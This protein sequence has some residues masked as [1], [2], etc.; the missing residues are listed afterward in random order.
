VVLAHL[1][2]VAPPAGAAERKGPDGAYVLRLYQRV[3]DVGNALLEHEQLVILRLEKKR[4][5]D[6]IKAVARF[7]S[8]RKQMRLLNRLAR[9]LK[10]QLPGGD[11]YTSRIDDI[12]SGIKPIREAHR[13]NMVRFKALAPADLV[14]AGN[15]IDDI[16]PPESEDDEGNFPVGGLDEQF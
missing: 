16:D 1:L 7:R 13:A 8:A 6:V 5:V 15:L 9:S 4:P 3:L 11:P 14:A 10:K 12:K 2:A